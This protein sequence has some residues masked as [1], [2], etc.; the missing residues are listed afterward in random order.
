MNVFVVNKDTRREAGDEARAGNIAAAKAVADIVRST[1]GPRSMLKMVLDPMGGIVLTSDGNTILREIDVAHPAAKTMLELSRAQ[2]EE[3]GDGTTT[4]IVLAGELVDAARP[5]LEA[6]VHPIAI[7]TGFFHALEDA[8]A[9][10]PSL[11]FRVDTKN[12]EDMERCI[13]SSLGTKATGTWC[14]KLC[15]LARKA[16]SIV[17]RGSEPGAPIDLKR[18]AKV[19]KVPGASIEDCTVLDGV[20][21]NKDVTGPTMAR[22]IENPRIVLVDCPIEYRKAE[23]QFNVELTQAGDFEKMLKLEEDY[24]ARLVSDILAVHPNVLITEKGVSDLA[25]HLLAEAGVSVIRRTRKTDLQRIAKASGARIVHRTRDLNEEDVG[26][27]AKLF[28]VKTIGDE[29][30]TFITGADRAQACTILLRG[31]AK[32]VLHEVERSLQD[33]MNVARSIVSDPLLVV[34]GGAFEMALSARLL[35]KAATLGGEE[36]LAYEAVAHTL[37]VIPRTLIG[38]CGASVIRLITELRSIHAAHSGSEPCPMGVDGTAGKICDMRAAGIWDPYATKIQ[39]IK[40]AVENACM[41]L[42]IDGLLNAR[43]SRND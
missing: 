41:L 6:H 13:R 17:A 25:E 28:E 32:D 40:G 21:I 19:E 20:M 10:G 39:A 37:E 3:V 43:R 33:A 35:S 12:S 7:T 22:R 15:E 36:R 30:F 11:T 16:V 26:T 38:N 5:L 4:A 27:W 18:F 9:I 23:S 24:V 14:D 31:A 2:D 42:R 8:L 29:P 1:L 34:G